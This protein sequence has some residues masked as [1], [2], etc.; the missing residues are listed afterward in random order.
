MKA[1]IVGGGPVGC[2]LG[3]GLRRRAFEVAIYDKSDDPRTNGS[4]QGHS[5]NLTLSERALQALGRDLSAQQYRHGVR[6]THRIVHHADGLV[7]AQPYGVSSDQHL[8]TI[9][10]TSLHVSL[11]N[12]AERAGA[13]FH[14]NHACLR[15]D[16]VGAS[17]AFAVGNVVV[18][19]RGD[20]LAGCDGANSV[21]RQE[22]AQHG[23]L[24]VTQDRIDYA[25]V[26][27]KIPAA[28]GDH[29]LALAARR[30]VPDL[31]DGFHLWPRGDFLLIAQPNTDG[32]YTATLFLPLTAKGPARP[33]FTQLGTAASVEQFFDRHFPDVAA[34]VPRLAEDFY[35]AA[36]APLKS[37]RCSAL[38]H[39]QTM[40]LGDAAHTMLPFYGQ[41]VN[42]GFEDVHVALDLLD[43][44]GDAADCRRMIFTA[45]SE[46]T[47]ARRGPG[48]AIIQLSRDNLDKLSS[49]RQDDGARSRLERELHRRYPALFTPLYCA[50]AFST[51]P[52]DEVAA[53]D[54][55]AQRKLNALCRRFDVSSDADRI[56][57]AFAAETQSEASAP[58]S[59]PSLDLTAADRRQ[60]LQ[61]VTM[62]ILDHE[63]ALDAGRYPASYVHDS[64]NTAAYDHG[65]LVSG[66]LR[67]DEIPNGPSALEPLL[68]EIFNVAFPSGTIHAHK[69]FMAHVP[70][71]GLLQ[72]A[73]GSFIAGA[74]NSFA[75]VWI[76]APGLIQLESNV[77]RWFCTLLGYGDSSFGY[78]TTSGSLANMMGLA[79]AVEAVNGASRSSL[80]VYTSD[81]AHFSVEKACRLIGILP[82]QLRIIPTRSDYTMDAEKLVDRIDAD[83]R[84]G[85]VPACVV[86][87]AGTTNTGAV[88]DLEDIGCVCR[89]RGVWFHVDACLGGFF[90]IT[91]RGRAALRGIE[92]ADSIAV[93][94][95]KSLF[96]PHGNSA[97]LVRDRTHLVATFQV[98]GSEY[99]PGRAT[100]AGLVDFCNCGPELSREIRGLT[101]WL[102]I[103]LH[104][105]A[106]FERRL[107]RM[108]DLAIDLEARLQRIPA[109]EV[110]R[111]HPMHLP[112]V[113]FKVRTT[114]A[115]D[116]AANMELCA[117][118]CS[119]GRVYVT[120]TS[121]PGFGTVVRACLLNHRTDEETVGMLVDDVQAALVR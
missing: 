95:H 40:L 116:A 111:L 57:Q 99:L 21:I 35:R 97:L 31:E 18:E 4:R 75:G 118:I 45:L 51:T 89:A 94:G 85:M 22:L 7:S 47:R 46:F 98:P 87:T 6:L 112:I 88:D 93:D 62:R 100:D 107:D 28:A 1:V 10:R 42:C 79:C 114:R 32:S 73:L 92:T 102:P 26:E 119:R 101:A 106:A 41:G 56:I 38:H 49:D 27:L 61:A 76:A 69:G 8:L 44:Y 105:V 121:L 117:R 115:D 5:F 16:P 52:Y 12:A 96:L 74:L 50:V 9:S 113:A 82:A 11:V 39:G 30:A 17:A 24:T 15:G 109:I 29:S 104:G 70:S 78:L 13:T 91:A 77:I 83:R 108:L 65:R 90:R 67:E 23:A 103:K 37:V 33:C 86:A 81:Q 84:A 60:L 110:V 59:M 120:T 63:A 68:A 53:R 54:A 20:L 72:G 19:D 25:Y 64:V 14:F 34:L 66:A 55:S 43:R 58:R 2:L 48:D 3:I 36:P 71:G 80:T